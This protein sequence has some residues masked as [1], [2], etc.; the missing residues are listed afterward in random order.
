M[1][2]DPLERLVRG[3]GQGAPMAA[4]PHPHLYHHHQ[5]NPNQHHIM[6]ESCVMCMAVYVNVVLISWPIGGL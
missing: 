5:F 6:I 2:W 3:A 1:A 4:F